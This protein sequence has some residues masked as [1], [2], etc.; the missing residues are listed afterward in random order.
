M[1]GFLSSIAPVLTSVFMTVGLVWVFF[2]VRAVFRILALAPPGEKMRVY[3]RL[4]MWNFGALRTDL[5]P[6][7]EPHL[8]TMKRGALA[9]LA[10]F[11]AVIVIAIIGIVSTS[12]FTGTPDAN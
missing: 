4:S 11:A 2:M 6:A 3:N 12:V 1:T 8:K 9:F 7:V 10:M 5:G